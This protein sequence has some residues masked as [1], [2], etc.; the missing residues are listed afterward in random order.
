MSDLAYQT[1]F[2]NALTS[3]ARPGAVPT[4]QNSPKDVPHGLYAEQINGSGFTVRRSEN[5]RVWMYRLRPQIAQAPYRS[6]PEGMWRSRFD[7]AS[8]S[9]ALIRLDP[10]PYP[11]AHRDFV[12]G[13]STFAGAGSPEL[14]TGFAIHLYAAT[15]DMVD[16]AFSNTDGD[17]L[18][19]PQEGRLLIR[20]ELG[21]LA[22]APGEIAILP[23]GIR[24]SV[25]LPDRRARGFVGELYNGHYQLPERGLVG[26]N[27]LADERH[28]KA[29]VASYEDRAAAHAIVVKQGGGFWQTTSAHSPFDVVGWHGNYSPFKYD[30]MDFACHWAVNWDHPDP[31]ILTVL[32]GAHDDHGNNAVDF[33]VFRGRWD[34]T[35]HT[36]RP[37]FFHRNAAIEFNAVIK[38]PKGNKY[39]AG[40]VTF[41]PFLSPHGI[42]AEAYAEAVAS[43]EA[44]SRGSDDELWI[45]FES[46]Y[47]LK[48]MPWFAD[49][50][51]GS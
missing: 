12:E 21:Y 32:T 40:T 28:F 17:L 8:G 41:T 2:G 22:V 23:R 20:T 18:V 37:P 43:S 30:L 10:Q 42:S 50:L 1:G 27:G 34:P 25:T 24:F 45:Q 19:V 46:T 51:Q 3:E 47:A 31:S 36:L 15:A 38:A 29:P 49:A 26:A 7:D 16:K 39:P 11:A 5:Q 9:P 44:P 33:A 35:E 6:V 48:V 13:F 14:R 4:Q